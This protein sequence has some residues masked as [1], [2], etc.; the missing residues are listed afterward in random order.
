MPCLGYPPT[1]LFYAQEA[2][3]RGASPHTFQGHLLGGGLEGAAA[4]NG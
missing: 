3:A 2:E 4:G 1:A